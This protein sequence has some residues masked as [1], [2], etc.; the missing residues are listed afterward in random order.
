[1]ATYKIPWGKN[2][3]LEF[4]LPKTWNLV[5]W[6]IPQEIAPISD[7]SAEI[8]NSLSQPIDS[9][10]LSELCQHNKNVVIIVDDISR[11]TPAHLLIDD[12]F[13]QLLKGGIDLK[14]VVMIPGLGVHRDMTQEEMEKKVGKNNLNKINWKNHNYKNKNELVYLGTTSRKI[15]AY[16]NKIVA[17]AD[18]II[19][20]GTIE[21]HVQAGFG[22]GYKNIL[23]G[24][25]GAETIAKNHL[26]SAH[27]KNFNMIGSLP[28]NNPMRLDIE[29]VGK[30]LHKPVF[31]VNTILNHQL[32]IL[33][34]VCGHPI[35]AHR[36]GIKTAMKIYGIPVE[37]Q[38]DIVITNSFPMDIDL[39]QAVKSIINPMNAVKK[40]GIILAALNCEQ[41]IGDASL[42]GT[43]IPLSLGFMRFIA[44]F[45]SPIIKNC[46]VGIPMEARFFVYIA[47][48]LIKRNRI[49]FYAPTLPKEMNRQFPAFKNFESLQTA[50]TEIKEKYYPT[51]DVIVFPFGGVSYPIY[52]G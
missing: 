4:E 43:K 16:V 26:L 37:K 9:P 27:P 14:N 47:L 2:D 52:Q 36:E 20:V 18:V 38:A 7:V 39:R 23:P 13:L 29:E 17:E 48:Q 33:K 30:M 1:M 46:Q 34:I 40:D 25:A 45:L 12:I 8:K 19:L 50:I 32:Q 28:E 5:K 51:A 49:F 42:S 15:P 22:G 41:G 11:P 35:T 21:P 31:I 24:V 3:F 6:A 44:R 10:P